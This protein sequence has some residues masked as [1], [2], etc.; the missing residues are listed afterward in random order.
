MPI[1]GRDLIIYILENRLEDKEISI[2]N[3]LMDVNEAAVKFGVGQST[4]EAWFETGKLQGIRIG[5][6]LYF[7]K[8]YKLG[9]NQ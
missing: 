6:G 1:T 2:S 5:G 8:D 9:G 3:I 7:P 4:I